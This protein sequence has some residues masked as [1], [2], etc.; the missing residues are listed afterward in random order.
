LALLTGCGLVT[1]SETTLELAL[2]LPAG[3]DPALFWY[4]VEKRTLQLRPGERDVQEV[5]WA[6]GARVEAKVDSGDSVQFLGSDG[7]G[8]ILVK[9]QGVVAEKKKATIRLERVL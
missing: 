2:E 1:R 5:A 8:R 6:G 7:S 4:G 9:G 3:E